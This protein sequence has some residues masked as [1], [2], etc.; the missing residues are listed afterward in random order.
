MFTN[1]AALK[2]Q[3][4]NGR[5]ALNVPTNLPEGTEVEL[6]VVADAWAGMDCG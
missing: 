5:L 2:A 1:V 3:V 4:R 6:Q